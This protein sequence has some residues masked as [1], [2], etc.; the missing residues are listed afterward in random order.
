MKIHLLGIGVGLG[1]SLITSTVVGKDPSS[2]L[3]PGYKETILDARELACVDRVLKEMNKR[4]LPFNRLQMVIRNAGDIY[5]V[6]FVE[7]ATNPTANENDRAIEW[8]VRKSDLKVEGPI[9]QR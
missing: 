3:Y 5:S 6:L 4:K 7:N 2:K 9:F 1:L 8:H